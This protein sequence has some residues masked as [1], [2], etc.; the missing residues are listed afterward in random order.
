[1]AGRVSLKPLFFE[2]TEKTNK[3]YS[4]KCSSVFAKKFSKD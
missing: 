1:M 4:C 2:N 3:M